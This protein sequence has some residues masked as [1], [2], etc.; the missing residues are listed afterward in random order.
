MVDLIQSDHIA[1]RDIP[2]KFV[3]LPGNILIGLYR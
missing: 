1:I 2:H 3:R